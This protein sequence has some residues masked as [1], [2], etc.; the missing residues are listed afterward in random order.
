MTVLEA[1]AAKAVAANQLSGEDYRAAAR[2]WL[3]AN[4]PASFRSDSASFSPP[5]L[6][7]S[8]AW[9][10]A[11]HRVGLTG[12]TWPQ[13]YGGHGRTLREHLIA[14]QEIGALAMPESVNS[15]GKEL[16]GPDHSRRRHRGAEAALP[17]RDPRD[18]RHL[19]PGLLRTRSRLGP[20]RPAHARH[21]QRRDLAD[22][23]TE[24]L[25][26]RRLSRTTLPRAGA[27]RRPGRPASRAGDVCGAARCRGRA[28]AHHQIDR[29]TGKLLRGLLRRC[30][31][32][33]IRCARGTR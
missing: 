2:S 12:I 19:V 26:Q 30:G 5:T 25:D 18:A 11:M 10:A 20:R 22:R 23:R 24:D 16:A 9:E 8:I 21:A 29:R 33:R 4:L 14:N 3:R 31:S 6:Q 17:A 15:I 27:H 7:A 32:V 28:S 1:H 13:A